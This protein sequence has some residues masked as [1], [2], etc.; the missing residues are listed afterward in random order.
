MKIHPIVRIVA[1]AALA[2]GW[3]GA[4][5]ARAAS[6]LELTWEKAQ[7]AVPD[8][9]DARG[10]EYITDRDRADRL[11][12]AGR[13]LPVVIY[14]HGCTG[15]KD[16]D[17]KFMKRIAKAGYVVVAPDSMARKYRPPQ[18][19]S[20]SKEGLDNFFVFDFRQEEINFAA[21]KMFTLKW[22]DTD[23]LFLVG[24]SEGGLAAALYRGPVFKA[25]VI[26]QW[27]CHGSSW[28][29][30]IDGPRDT[31]I[32][33]IVRKNDPWYK[34]SPGQAGDCGAYFGD[35]RPGSESVVLD[36]GDTHDVIDD[37]QQVARIIA[38]LNR[39]NTA[40]K[41]AP[42]PRRDREFVPLR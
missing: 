9:V 11:S 41:P 27:T 19:N 34:D 7:S 40:S 5:P 35:R 37:Q 20:F 14:M 29:E 17:R 4:A 10:I 12:E 21:R 15:L 25:R 38:F 39:Y 1:L 32:L 8:E 3:L 6:D 30:G 31:P 24:T 33:S 28:V 23:N 42:A 13:K 22:A 36:E 18:C 16:A 2:A 26:T